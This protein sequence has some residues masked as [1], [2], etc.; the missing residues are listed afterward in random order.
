MVNVA[1]VS[2]NAARIVLEGTVSGLPELTE[3]WT[4]TVE[5]IGN[6]PGL[7]AQVRDELVAKLDEKQAAW[8]TAQLALS[9]L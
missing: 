4:V 5:A 7:L 8:E 9:S 6:D 2:Q 3:R 1:V